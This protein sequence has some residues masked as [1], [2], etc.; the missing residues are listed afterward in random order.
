MAILTRELSAPSSGSLD[1][2]GR[3]LYDAQ[4]S[5]G[6]KESSKSYPKDRRKKDCPHL[7]P[8]L[9]WGA[10]PQQLYAHCKACGAHCVILYDRC[11]W[12]QVF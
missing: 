2:L 11:K 8:N 12:S 9:A 7:F 5:H 3:Y 1:I 6:K 4:K 10:D